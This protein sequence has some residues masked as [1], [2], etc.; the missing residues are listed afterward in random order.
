MAAERPPV[1][2]FSQLKR[3]DMVD[4]ATSPTTES[5][6]LLLACFPCGLGSL[7]PDILQ[8]ALATILHI[9]DGKPQKAVHNEVTNLGNRRS[10]ISSSHILIA[11][12][13][14]SF[15]DSN[16]Y[17]RGP[18][19]GLGL[20][21]EGEED[22]NIIG[23]FA[24]RKSANNDNRIEITSGDESREEHKVG[25]QNIAQPRI[26]D[27]FRPR[28]PSSRREA[29]EMFT[30]M[31]CGKT[32]VHRQFVR[33]SPEA[34]VRELFSLVERRL[35]RRTKGQ[36]VVAIV[37]RRSGQFEEYLVEQDDPDTW[38]EFVK[39]AKRTQKFSDIK[40]TVEFKI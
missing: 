8:C 28:K 24:K 26:D 36:E 33:V 34:S 37:L 35:R 14:R 30:L 31:L 3:G 25:V 13:L 18:A 2:N 27:V 29:A 38:E 19:R 10:R 20:I 1:V 39:M 11:N 23:A 15:F 16:G 21:R 32:L 9:L 40:A 7:Q 17:V 4:I 6:S 12:T 22:L 5:I